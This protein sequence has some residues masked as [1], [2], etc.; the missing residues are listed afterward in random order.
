MALTYINAGTPPDYRSLGIYV[1]YGDFKRFE[2]LE[3]CTRYSHMILPD[4]EIC[5]CASSDLPNL[6]SNGYD[7]YVDCSLMTQNSNLKEFMINYC[8]YQ[9]PKSWLDKRKDVGSG[10]ICDSA[11]LPCGSGRIIQKSY[12]LS[13]IYSILPVILFSN[14]NLY[15]PSFAS[16]ITLGSITSTVCHAPFGIWHP[17]FAS[18][19]Q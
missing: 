11:E 6:L 18:A 2:V 7:E 17:Y 9:N 8:D 1:K 16:N 19:G 4:R 15:I 13:L 10:I 3:D 14:Q 12:P 5:I